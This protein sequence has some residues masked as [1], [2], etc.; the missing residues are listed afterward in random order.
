MYYELLVSVSSVVYLF[1]I[2][3]AS[4]IFLLAQAGFQATLATDFSL[5]LCK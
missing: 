5:E 1:I 2:V 3:G 4:L